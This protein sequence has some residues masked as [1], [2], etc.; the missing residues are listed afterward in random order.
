MEVKQKGD[1]GRVVGA[2]AKAEL[3]KMVVGLK[4]KPGEA[5]VAVTEPWLKPKN[6]ESLIP[7]KRRLVKRMMFD[8]LLHF[9]ASLFGVQGS[10]TFSGDPFPNK[11]S[12]RLKM[13]TPTN[14][15][16]EKNDSKIFP[17]Q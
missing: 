6:N 4:V 13:V 14:V 1:E 2:S 9:T 8:C 11:A 10:P 17:Y 5:A 15:K 7:P 12:G 3:P 16:A